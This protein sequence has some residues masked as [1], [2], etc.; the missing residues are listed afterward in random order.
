V[1]FRKALGRQWQNCQFI[2]GVIVIDLALAM[3]IAARPLNFGQDFAI[4]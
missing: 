3:S 1:I 4:K 2:L